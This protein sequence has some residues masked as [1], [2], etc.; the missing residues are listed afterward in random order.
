MNITES[1]PEN[2]SRMAR[3]MSASFTRR[4]CRCA[5]RAPRDALRASARKVA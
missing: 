3:A 5:P 2:G 1:S 4:R